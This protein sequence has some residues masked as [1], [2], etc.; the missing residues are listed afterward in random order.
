MLAGRDEAIGRLESRLNGTPAL[1][2]IKGGSTDEVL[3]FIAAALDRRA[4]VGD[5]RLRA[6]AAFVDQMA[7][8]R[9]LA[10]RASL[11][12]LVP[13]TA[14]VASEAAHGAPHHIVVPVIG[15]AFA[16]IE[17]PPIDSSTAAT[18]LCDAGLGDARAEDA[19]R[20]ARRSLLGLRRSLAIKPELHAPAWASSLPRTLRG[21]LLAGR[22]NEEFGADRTAITEITGGDFDTLRDT[23]AELARAKIPSSPG[24]A[25]PGCWCLRRMRGYNSALRSAGMTSTGSNRC[26]AGSSSNRTVPGAER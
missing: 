22:W 11:L 26:C 23:L 19:G 14:D 15:A 10:G 9:A 3:A 8:W 13:R 1:T 25:P 6:R 16:D 17:L 24:S 7:S 12:I 18:V 4:R 21:L 20:M 5:S 2:T